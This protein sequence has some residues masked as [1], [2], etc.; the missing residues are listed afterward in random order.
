[1]SPKAANDRVKDY[2]RQTNE[3]RKIINQKAEVKRKLRAEEEAKQLE[4]AIK[5]TIP[6]QAEVAKK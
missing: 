4:L 6:K 1:M 3:R 2:H 5:E